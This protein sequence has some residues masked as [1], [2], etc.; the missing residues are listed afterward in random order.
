VPGRFGEFNSATV[1]HQAKHEKAESTMPARIVVVYDEQE[2]IDALAGALRLADYEVVGFT[3]PMAALQVFETAHSIE[4]LVTQVRFA[5]QMPNGVSVALMARRQRPD[6]KVLFVALAEYK[7]HTE[8]IGE[9]MALPVS[10]PEL[11]LSV[12][13]LLKP[14][15]QISN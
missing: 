12:K 10:I 6:M 1:C 5:P 7:A 9:F 3:N 13:R 11:V 4:L 2:F 14:D 15:G 8:G